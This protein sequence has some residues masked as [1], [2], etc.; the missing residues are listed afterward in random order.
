MCCSKILWQFWGE[1]VVISYVIDKLKNSTHRYI[2]LF[3]DSQAAILSITNANYNKSVQVH[4][5]KMKPF[6]LEKTREN[7]VVL[8]IP[9][10]HNIFGNVQANTLAKAGSYMAQFDSH[11]HY[12]IIKRLFTI[13]RI[14]LY[15]DVA[16]DKRWNTLLNKNKKNPQFLVSVSWSCL[17]ITKYDFLQKHVFW[18][19]VK[20]TVSCPLWH[21]GDMY[22]NHFKN[23]PTILKFITDN[24]MKAKEIF[25]FNF[26][27]ALLSSYWT[28]HW[29]MAKMSLTHRI[30]KIMKFFISDC[31]M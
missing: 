31:Y 15:A 24:S 2:V 5:C 30:K 27:F 4:S 29:L 11:Y 28:A 20:D 26:F 19:G 9:S 6:N 7:I 12:V 10:H 3:I 17:M 22:G 25:Y 8:W 23:C 18:M 21:Q 16:V 14:F 13:N 1:T